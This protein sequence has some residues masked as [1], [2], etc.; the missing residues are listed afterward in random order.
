MRVFLKISVRTLALIAATASIAW[1]QAVPASSM[2]PNVGPGLPS[3]DGVFHYALS[4]SEL[5]QTGNGSGLGY[6]TA[7]SG[8]A[9]YNS[10]S[11][12]RPFSM[13][14]A[15]GLLLGNQYS[16]G[17][18]TYQ[19][20]A[21]SQGLVAGAWIFGISD[22]VSYLPQSPTLG[23]SGIPGVGDL[24]SQPIQGPSSGPAG[25]VLTNNST[26]VSNSLSGDVERRL[27]PLTSISGMGSWSILR[28]PDGNGLESTQIAAQGALNH[29]LDARDTISGS[30]T[31]STFSYGSGIDLS[32]Q[33][34]GG[35][36]AFQRVLSRKLSLSAS[37]GPMWISSSN[38]TLV[39]SRLTVATDLS[40]LY[41]RKVTTASLSYTRGVNGGS[42]V[43]PGALSDSVGVMVGRTYG[44]DWV[45]SLTG[46][47]THS[48]GLVQNAGLSGLPAAAFLYAGGTTNLAYGGAQVTRRL[49]DSLSAYASYN[50]QHQSIDSTLLLQ[51]A[52]S[53][54]NQ[55]FGIGITFSPRS[56][57]LGQF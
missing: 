12:V 17:A 20:L 31:Y 36:L 40:L 19:N 22:S 13:T 33:T 23:L 24:G 8:D 28:F 37:A 15:G 51:N 32:I 50:L 4:G 56:T 7:L 11:V 46:S 21:L 49:S 45:A 1:G 55:T 47:Y 6:S 5:F 16:H 44:R 35:N 9:S 25:G 53:G 14:Y 18:T 30:G 27:T 34:R 38:S 10:R 41:S 52:Y 54:F 42:G 57:R 2:S 3:I 39:P 29:R 43:Q 48:G 26:N